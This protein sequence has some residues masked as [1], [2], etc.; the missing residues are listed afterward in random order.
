M[1]VAMAKVPSQASAEAKRTK[2]LEGL[3]LCI[4]YFTTAAIAFKIFV[5]RGFM[6]E[7]DELGELEQAGVL[8]ATPGGLDDNFMISHADNHGSFIVSNDRFHDHATQRGYDQRWLDYHRVPFMCV[9]YICSLE[10]ARW[11]VRPKL[12]AGS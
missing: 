6:D 3:M 11:Q 2:A 4:E 9:H 10:P 8:F 5:P 7:Y 12:C 1:N